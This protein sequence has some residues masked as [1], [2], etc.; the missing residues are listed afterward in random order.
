MQ[1]PQVT[2]IQM[3]PQQQQMGYQQPMQQQ[4]YPMQQQQM[5]YQQPMQQQGYPMQQQP[6]MA[7]GY[8]MQMTPVQTPKKYSSNWT[9]CFSDIPSCLCVYLFYPCA[10]CSVA[11]TVCECE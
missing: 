11:D 9:D 3:T 5:G 6:Q 10:I 2:I 4:G 8:A 7:P 1:Q